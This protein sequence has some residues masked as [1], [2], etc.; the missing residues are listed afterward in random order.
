VPNLDS[1]FVERRNQFLKSTLQKLVRGNPFRNLVPMSAF[2]LTEGREPT[3]RTL[4]HEL[5]T[6]YPTALEEVVVSD[7]SGVTMCQPTAT[8]IKRGEV[9]RT[10]K[11]YQASFDTD[12]VCLSD[13][14]RAEQMANA[15]AGF[16]RALNEYLQVWWSD[17]YRIQ[18]IA[19]AG[20]KASTLAAG[21][22]N[23]V[24]STKADFSDLTTFPTTDLS[25]DHLRKIYWRLCRNGAAD[26]LAIGRDSKGRP[27]LPLCAGP[28]ILGALWKDD[29]H[30]KEQVKFF[31]S[32][33]NLKVLGYDGAI[34]GFL[35]VVDLF[36]IRFG[37]GTAADQSDNIAAVA[38][39]VAANMVYPTVNSAATN[40][41]KHGPNVKY[42]VA[43]VGTAAPR[44]LCEVVT[45][46][47]KNVY[48]AKYEAVD[49]SSFSGMNFKPQNYVGE[50]KWINNPT[51]RGTN[52]RQNQGYYLA[53]VRVGAKPLFPE[54]GYS[55]ITKA[56]DI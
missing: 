3:V 46:L 49:P 5:P 39:L 1:Y 19:M 4:T 37:K 8:T 9:Q 17:W 6:A 7:N 21:A 41:R 23:V 55:I 18:N 20:N 30:V 52:D 38:D 12:T 54:L 42:D 36:P 56:R 26:E 22:L 10:F 13:L 40:G 34:D 33:Q 50:F 11:L 2:D 51:F 53:D 29:T 47:G 44:A 43:V 15:A 25:W 27:I 24:E 28:A 45:I 14:K 35:P 16:E 48:E 32:A 31:D